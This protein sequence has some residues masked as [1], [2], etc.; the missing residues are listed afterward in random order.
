[1]KRVQ[2]QMRIQESEEAKDPFEFRLNGF[3]E[4]VHNRFIGIVRKA[5]GCLYL[6]G[7]TVT[8]DFRGENG[9][10][11]SHVQCDFGVQLV[12]FV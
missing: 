9:F 5:E 1:M 6:I 11:Q 12:N 10:D 7:A 8:H 2:I 3:A 4:R